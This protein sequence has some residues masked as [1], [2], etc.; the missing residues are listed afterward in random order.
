[1]LSL[2]FA[3]VGCLL[4]AQGLCHTLPETK[5]RTTRDTSNIPTH[6]FK[7][8]G[9]KSNNEPI[10]NRASENGNGTTYG[11]DDSVEFLEKSSGE[12]EPVTGDDNEE[13]QSWQYA[14]PTF[15]TRFPTV[16][17]SD[18]FKTRFDPVARNPFRGDSNFNSRPFPSSPDSRLRSSVPFPEPQFN[19]PNRPSWVPRP[20]PMQPSNSIIP[21]IAGGPNLSVGPSGPNGFGSSSNNFYRS[22]SYSITS[23]G[24]G[25]PQIERDVYDSRDGFGSSFRN[26]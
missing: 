5:G 1:M 4:I 13:D 19:N 6:F 26:F 18:S 24:R 15:N 2:H 17:Q 23:D 9:R 8:V 12:V 10:S 7:P 11:G 25:P 20:V 21:L 3:L 14:A 22:E 16:T